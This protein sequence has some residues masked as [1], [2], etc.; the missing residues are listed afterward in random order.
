[1]LCAKCKS[2]AV[3]SSY[4]ALAQEMR[5]GYLLVCMRMLAHPW[6]D[7][8]AYDRQRDTHAHLEPDMGKWKY[9]HELFHSM[10][11]PTLIPVDAKHTP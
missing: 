4:L 7:V 2:P 1:M 11:S 5:G 6:M 3:C 9:A 8:S 10:D